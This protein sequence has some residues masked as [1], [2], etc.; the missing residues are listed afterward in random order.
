MAVP[1][2]KPLGNNLD[3]WKLM[4]FMLLALKFFGKRH[5]YGGKIKVLSYFQKMK[6][7]KIIKRVCSK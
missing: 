5:L 4:L 6:H 7:Y 2:P 3:F 1:E